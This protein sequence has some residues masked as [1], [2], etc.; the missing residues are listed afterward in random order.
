MAVSWPCFYDGVML[1][2][3]GLDIQLGE[4]LEGITY[5]NGDGATYAFLIDATGQYIMVRE[6]VGT[7]LSF[8][9]NSCH[10]YVSLSRECCNIS[11]SISSVVKRVFKYGVFLS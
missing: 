4:L 7:L 1:G 11:V 10:R 2:V 6:H 5:F 8:A 3:A 9:F